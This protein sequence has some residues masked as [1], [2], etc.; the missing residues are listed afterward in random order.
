MYSLL[1]KTVQVFL[2][3]LGQYFIVVMWFNNIFKINFIFFP[4]SINFGLSTS[5]FSD[6]DFLWESCTY[7]ESIPS[8]NTF[9]TTQ[10]LQLKVCV[11]ITVL[12]LLLFTFKKKLYWWKPNFYFNFNA[13]LSITVLHN[14]VFHRKPLRNYQVCG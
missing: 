10:G 11:N 4:V 5:P 1:I 13:G 12:F 7:Q 3:G 2:I 8:A 14:K 6:H 9:I